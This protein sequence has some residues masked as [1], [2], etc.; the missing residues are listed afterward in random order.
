LIGESNELAKQRYFNGTMHLF[1]YKETQKIFEEARVR[2]INAQYVALN[3]EVELK[4]L[5]GVL[6]S[7]Y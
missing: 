6:L 5:N 1:E 7:G 3:A 4:K 2:F